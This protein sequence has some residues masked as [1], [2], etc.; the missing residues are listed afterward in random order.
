MWMKTKSAK[1]KSF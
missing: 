1:T